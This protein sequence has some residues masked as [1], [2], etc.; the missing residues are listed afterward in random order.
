MKY[1]RGWA[2]LAAAVV[3][4]AVVVNSPAADDNVP[5]IKKIMKVANAGGNSFVGKAEKALKAP[6]PNFAE[7][8]DLGKKLQGCAAALGKNKPKKGDEASWEKLTKAYAAN[9]KD[10][11]EA[12]A[13]KDKAGCDAALKAIKGSCSVCHKA[14]K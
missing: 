1:A 13:K 11:T 5:D 2:A 6:E 10:L 12:A 8:E 4:G 3:V 9:V 14:H 7:I